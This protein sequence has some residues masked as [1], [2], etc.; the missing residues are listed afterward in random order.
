MTGFHLTDGERA[1]PMWSRIKAHLVG[2]LAELRARNDRAAPEQET[3]D[4]RGR[5]AE[6]KAF[7][8]L[9][10]DRPIIGE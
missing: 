2:R 5:I 8:A 9:G 3:A 7:I 6:C 4:C 10:D 1:H